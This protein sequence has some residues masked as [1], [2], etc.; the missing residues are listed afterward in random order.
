MIIGPQHKRNVA[1]E[2]KTP[3]AEAQELL[4]EDGPDPVY[5]N[6]LHFEANPWDFR[7]LFG[8]L[9]P[10]RFKAE[11]DEVDWCADVTIPWAQ[12]KLMH[13]FLGINIGIYELE[14]GSISIPE[15]VLPQAPSPPSADSDPRSL[16]AY[17]LVKSEIEKL[18][19]A[20]VAKQKQD[21]GQ[22]QESK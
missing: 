16:A 13:F 10:Q 1:M 17:E 15:R 22:S 2:D 4:A 19:A 20:Q 14:N 6:Y 7:I 21:A 12:A 11:E 18:R 3:N 5:A 8:Q 9:I